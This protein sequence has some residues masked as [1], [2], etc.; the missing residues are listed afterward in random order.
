MINKNRVGLI[1]VIWSILG[2]LLYNTGILSS[3]S[4]ITDFLAE[5]NS[6]NGYIVFVLISV[7][8][9]VLFVPQTVLIIVGSVIF[10]PVVGS[11]LSIIALFISQSI[12]YMLGRFSS[13]NNFIKD[14][15]SSNNKYGNLINKYGYRV[16]AMGIICPIAPSDLIVLITG[17]LRLNYIKSILVIVLVDSPMIFLYSLS[18]G[19]DTGYITK[20][21][22]II[23]ILIISVYGV[24]L[25]NNLSKRHTIGG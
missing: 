11:I 22:S 8:R 10:G 16:L 3:S 24:Y 20:I 15:I 19:M 25:F 4:S 18:I 14:K 1:I 21:I 13:D 5:C 2:L 6:L 23:S 17:Y 7:G 9:I 12:M